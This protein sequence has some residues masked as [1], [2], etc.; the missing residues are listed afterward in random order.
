[1]PFTDKQIQLLKPKN[2]RYDRREK[3]GN[4]FAIRV[5]PQNEKSWCFFYFFDGKKK[6]M[7]LGSYPELSLAEARKRHRE[8]MRLLE[9]GIDPST[10]KQRLARESR[11]AFTVTSLVKEYILIWAKPNKRSWQED[12]RLLYKD[13]VPL[14]GAHKARDI[15]RR[16]VMMLLDKVKDRGSPIQ[17]NRVLACVRRMFNFGIERDIV[18]INPCV[19]VKAVAKE[20]KR[21]RVLSAQEIKSLWYALDNNDPDIQISKLAKLALQFQLT[22][23]QRKGEVIH[24]EWNEVDLDTCFWTIPSSKSKNGIANR[25]PISELALGILQQIKSMNLSEKWIFPSE[26]KQYKSHITASS[27]DHA[28]R[29]SNFKDIEPAFV[30]H[31]LRR[32]AASHMTSMG[33]TRLTVSKILNHADNSIT[34]VYDRHSY[35][36]EKRIAL[37]VWSRRLKE[38]VGGNQENNVIPLKQ[39]I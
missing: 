4:G 36:N 39:A 26:K 17:S 33:I 23:A 18:K 25:V 16:D 37:E 13:I 2:V 31:D 15:T 30:P 1:M 29:R 21:D 19:L 14:W 34:A 22:T 28:V 7:T 27:V 9:A 5:S 38:I 35:D 11:E 8:A 10:E 32:T 3:S 12:E 20:N 24:A 6:R